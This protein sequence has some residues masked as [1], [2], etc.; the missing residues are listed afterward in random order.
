[1]QEFL[2]AGTG[3]SLPL[4]SHPVQLI[5]H[6]SRGRTSL[7]FIS[8]TNPIRIGSL[9]HSIT[10]PRSRNSCRISP[11]DTKL[12]ELVGPRIADPNKSSLSDSESC[13]HNATIGYDCSPA[14]SHNRTEPLT[15]PGREIFL[16]WEHPGQAVGPNNSQL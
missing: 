9:P 12:N 5:T 15:F 10:F 4:I 16:E 7:R 14:I 6:A 13:V 2:K 8:S 3:H 11:N 1:M